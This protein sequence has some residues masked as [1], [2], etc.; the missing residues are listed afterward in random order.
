[1]AGLSLSRF[2]DYES[3][4]FKILKLA[5]VEGIARALQVADW[6][7]LFPG[8]TQSIESPPKVPFPSDSP[9][10]LIPPQNQKKDK[11]ETPDFLAH[12]HDHDQGLGAP[13]KGR[14]A[15]SLQKDTEDDAVTPETPPVPLA[16]P[17]GKSHEKGARMAP[18]TFELTAE[19]VTWAMDAYPMV[20]IPEATAM[21]RDHEFAVPHRNWSAVWRNWIRRTAEM[22]PHHATKMRAIREER[23]RRQE[24][25]TLVQTSDA[26][27]FAEE[28]AKRALAKEEV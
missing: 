16:V 17:R 18:A 3:G 2:Y 23:A 15:P 9:S 26:P 21:F 28:R 14:H 12:T 24:F 20:D 7:E 22:D 1:M 5:E 6:R 13:Y 10:P 25:E 11:K 27:W 4:R 8:P 19:M